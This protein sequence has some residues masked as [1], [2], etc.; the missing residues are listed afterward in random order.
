ME[1]KTADP[2]RAR[3]V[4][5]KRNRRRLTRKARPRSVQIAWRGG[6]LMTGALLE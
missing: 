6:C 4:G 5:R 3:M 2:E 1:T